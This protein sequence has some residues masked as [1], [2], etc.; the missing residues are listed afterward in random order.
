[1]ITGAIAREQIQD[2]VRA[3]E[4]DRRAASMRR[5]RT[6]KGV[7]GLFAAIVG[8]NV[9]RSTEAARVYRVRTA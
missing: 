4:Q 7:S 5:P 8:S 9:D 1:M 2:R 6:R 3:A